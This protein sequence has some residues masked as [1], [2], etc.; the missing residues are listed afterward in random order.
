MECHSWRTYC[1]HNIARTFLFTFLFQ[2][3]DD[4]LKFQ[5]QF[6]HCWNLNVIIVF[7]IQQKVKN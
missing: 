2:T 3:T 5:Q 7:I 6:P 4:K 1:A